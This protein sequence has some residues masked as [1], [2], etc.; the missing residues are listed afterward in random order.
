[1]RV[2]GGGALGASVQTSTN[3]STSLASFGI[4]PGGASTAVSSVQAGAH[5]DL[6]TSIAFNTIGSEG[7]LAGDP[8]NTVDELPPGFA[9][10]LV[11]TPACAASAF[12]AHEC[13]TDTQVGVTTIT[14]SSISTPS[15]AQLEP[16]YNLAPDPG[17]VAKL[18][19]SVPPLFYEGNV[20]VRPGDY[21]LETTFYDA[22]AGPDEIDAVSLT[23][24]GVPAAAA[25]DP[26]R[27]KHVPGEAYG[28]FGAASELA[29]APYLTSPTACGA[30]AQPLQAG[31][32]V[33]S[34]QEPERYA[35][36][37]MPFGPFVGCDR[38]AMEPALAAESTTRSA[39]APSG[40]DVTMH[41]PQTYENASG[42]AT[43]TLK[44]AVV[45]LPQGMTVNPSAGA[46]LE[47]CSEAQYAQEGAV[48]EAGSG[49]PSASKLG[50]VKI[51]TPSLK[52]EATGS[53][54]LAQPYAN[55]F[56]SLLALY[57]VARIPN[58]GV[59]VKAAGEVSADPLT[60][61]LVT[62]FDDLPPLPFST[63]T[64]SFRQ[65]A[66]SPL[67]TPAS[68]GSY[69]VTAE[70]T[71]WA[72]PTQPLA[73]SA[74]PFAITDG[75]GGGA[76]PAA[77]A[78]P[79]APQVIAGTEGNAAGTY[80]PFYLRVV[81]EDDE[82]EL[83]RFSV[84][85]PPGLTGDL[86]G[87]PFCPDAAIEVA[88]GET[89]QRELNE[90]SCPAASEIG[91]TLV[92]AGVGDV[93]A[94][95]PGKVYLAGPY[96]GAPL[97]IVS[98][99]SATVGPFDLGTVVIR[100]A[101]RINPL[102]A[103]VEVDAS[104]SDPIPHIIDGIVVHVRDIH[105]YIDRHDFIRNPT[106]CAPMAIHSA[107]GGAG[108]TGETTVD[109][110]TYFQAADCAS[111]AFKPAFAASTTGRTSRADGAGLTVKLTFPTTQP[112]SQANIA[113]VK[114]ELPKRLPSRLSTLQK[115]CT[116]AQ[117]EANPAGC[118][119]AS[120]VGHARAITPIVP[121]PLEGPAY[122]VSHGGAAFPSLVVVL[123]GYGITIDL[124]GS[125]FISKRGITSSTFESVPDEPVQSFE[126]TLPK[127][128][129]SALAANGD[130]C[131]GKL[132]MPTTFTAQNGA[133]LHQSTTIH[134]TGCPK[135][136]R[137]RARRAK[138]HG[139]R[140]GAHKKRP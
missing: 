52:E 72:T 99:T 57:I 60:G 140:R 127:G 21:G 84:T 3:I 46:G 55:P 15:G 139:Q 113:K 110:S 75:V 80:A 18:G 31:F 47:G 35:E 36:T 39:S 58:R 122:F 54:F 9:G 115:A 33:D 70:L 42:L 79:F 86:T 23:V 69:Q 98:I 138:R 87:I 71:S 105:V 13:P 50:T 61:R 66:T 6:T 112:G 41:V 37:G 130:L 92:G 128:P 34:W 94:W 126:L 20:A 93:L 7:A 4:S 102:T 101:L 73:L 67:V 63:F 125:T 134:A 40:L 64:L 106:S 25:H 116:A 95:A 14:L 83:T 56:K 43:P 137:P 118:P 82:R 74:P 121:V 129:Y 91:H 28:S 135:A 24:W 5:P 104:S 81:R 108:E 10:D 30:N 59:L 136:K 100:F 1:M 29:P 76:C 107:T 133:E 12:L 90:P 111:L 68:C 49:C 88:R 120:V 77:G 2:A 124:V 117:F 78:Q 45:T 44:K 17:Y 38:L 53:V 132:V 109:Q 19:F 32:K 11:D 27:W 97:S 114:V 131:T 89:G 62:T 48:Y 8:K 123:Q 119:T 26:L 16:V 85:L 65:G 103:Q 96:H 51:T 22:T